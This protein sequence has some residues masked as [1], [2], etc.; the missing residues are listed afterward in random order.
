MDPSILTFLTPVENF[1]L[2]TKI[3]SEISMFKK[4]EVK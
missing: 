2:M 1:I 4:K 3:L